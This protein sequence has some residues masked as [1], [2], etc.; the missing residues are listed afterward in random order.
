MV[1]IQ[2]TQFIDA[3]R[4]FLHLTI[5]LLCEVRCKCR[6]RKDSL[7]KL[8]PKVYNQ[9]RTEHDDRQIDDADVSKIRV[10]TVKSQETNISIDVRILQVEIRELIR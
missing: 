6:I 1:V 2:L 3:I 4:L 9:L 5:Q 8:F 7:L 10:E